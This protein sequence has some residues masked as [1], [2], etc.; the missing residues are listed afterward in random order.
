MYRVCVE[1]AANYLAKYARA[2]RLNLEIEVLA[3]D[4]AVYMIE[5]YLRK[6]GFRI[7]RLS[8]YIHFGCFKVLFRDKERDLMEVSWDSIPPNAE[9]AYDAAGIPDES[10]EE[11]KV[12]RQGLLFEDPAT[13]QEIWT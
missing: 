6:P 2:R 11:V 7:R 4:A 9:P 12:F 3:H 13:G 8:A 1:I 5:Q 10:G